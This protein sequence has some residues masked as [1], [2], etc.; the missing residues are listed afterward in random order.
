MD[1]PPSVYL[2]K[3]RKTA[4][5]QGVTD[6]VRENLRGDKER[7]ERNSYGS[8]LSAF[9]SIGVS[10]SRSTMYKRVSRKVKQLKAQNISETPYGIVLAASSNS[11]SI[12]S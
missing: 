1:P 5:G 4:L 11:M 3:V 6:L 2:A 7:H 8:K 10:I 12:L 9:A